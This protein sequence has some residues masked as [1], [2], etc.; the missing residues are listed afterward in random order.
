ML[1]VFFVTKCEMRQGVVGHC[2]GAFGGTAT[3][4][5]SVWQRLF[6]EQSVL[7]LWLAVCF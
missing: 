2:N 4:K 3:V 1:V 5:A 6:P 7:F